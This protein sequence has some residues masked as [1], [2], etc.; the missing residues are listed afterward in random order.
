MKFRR[1][2]LECDTDKI[3]GCTNSSCAAA[4]LAGVNVIMAPDGWRGL[5]ENT[6]KQVQSGEIPMARLDEAV[7][8]ILH[9]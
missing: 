8:R 5:Y 1:R 4:Y 6:V 9:A 2:R 7:S 3:P